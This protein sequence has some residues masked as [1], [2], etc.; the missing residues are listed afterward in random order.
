MQKEKVK[1]ANKKFPKNEVYYVKHVIQKIDG[2]ISEIVKM[3]VLAT[4]FTNGPHY[5]Y[6]RTQG[7]ITYVRHISNSDL[8]VTFACKPK[9]S[10]I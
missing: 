2:Q 8:I 5:S 3:V 10:D 6:D 7:S 4:S 9:W 1:F